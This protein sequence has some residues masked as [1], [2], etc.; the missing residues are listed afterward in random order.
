[1]VCNR[2]T[3][4]KND[5]RKISDFYLHFT[6]LGAYYPVVRSVNPNKLIKKMYRFVE[7]K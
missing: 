2:C 1:M 7:L 3:I 4:W 6:A 5:I